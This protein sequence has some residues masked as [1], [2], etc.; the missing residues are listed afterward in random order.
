MHI[1]M[2]IWWTDK[3]LNLCT[4]Q[5][6]APVRAL[7]IPGYLITHVKPEITANVNRVRAAEAS[8]QTPGSKRATAR[9][10][11]SLRLECGEAWKTLH[12][13][14]CTA[15]RAKVRLGFGELK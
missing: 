1:Y 11:R 7:C 6:D 2:Y 5:R 3:F 10:G 13:P 12:L 14:R 8:G 15:W 4:A 9:Q